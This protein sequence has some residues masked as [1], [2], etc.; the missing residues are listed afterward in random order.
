MQGITG[1]P[2]DAFMRSQAEIDQF[3][4]NVAESNQRILQQSAT[5]LNTNQ[6]ETLD[7]LLTK[8]IEG[9]RVQAAAFFQNPAG[10]QTAHQ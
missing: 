10:S 7:R 5:F 2:D 4:H 3:L 9:R 6:L 8:S 1:A